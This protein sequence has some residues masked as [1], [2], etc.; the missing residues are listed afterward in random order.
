[1]RRRR[2]RER[3]RRQNETEEQ[4]SIRLNKQR[5]LNHRRRQTE[6]LQA[7]AIR[8][9]RTASTRNSV[10]TEEQRSSRLKVTSANFFCINIQLKM[11]EILY[12]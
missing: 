7:R 9:E 5:V 4:L 3:V 11:F 1:M 12:I 8:L 10:E 6:S 2:D